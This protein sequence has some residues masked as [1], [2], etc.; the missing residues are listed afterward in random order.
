MHPVDTGDMGYK[1][2]I[3]WRCT[4]FLC[5][6]SEPIG[7]RR[8]TSSDYR[9]I[10]YRLQ[11]VKYP[12]SRNQTLHHTLCALSLFHIFCQSASRYDCIVPKIALMIISVETTVPWWIFNFISNAVWKGNSFFQWKR[13]VI[14]SMYVE[15]LYSD[16]QNNALMR[17][18][19]NSIIYNMY[20]HVQ[21]IS[22][23]FQHIQC[24][25]N[26]HFWKTSTTWAESGKTLEHLLSIEKSVESLWAAW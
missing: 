9:H 26:N 10:S 1:I 18:L 4:I 23:I 12:T 24:H 2:T 17:K 21:L 20:K 19:M 6:Q 5:W 7:R 16:A 14:S 11:K 15:Q 22:L 8:S 3:T 13:N 25:R